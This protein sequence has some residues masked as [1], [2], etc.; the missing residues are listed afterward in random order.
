MIL[1][2]KPVMVWLHGGGYKFG[3]GVPHTY[4]GGPEFFMETQSVLLVSINYRLGPLGFL[5]LENESFPGNMGFRDQ[6]MALTWIRDHISEFGGDP[7]KVTI[8]GESVGG[9]SIL[10]LLTIPSAKGYTK[11]R[12]LLFAFL[13]ALLILFF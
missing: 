5:S 6:I 3:S 2:L 13:K 7:D 4:Y 11:M 10:L 8:F 12:L 9:L 1:G